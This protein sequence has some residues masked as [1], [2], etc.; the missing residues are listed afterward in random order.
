MFKKGRSRLSLFLDVPCCVLC[1][2]TQSCLTLCDPMDC[3]P[4]GSSV[5][6]ILQART[7]EWV[8]ISSSGRSSWPRDWLPTECCMACAG[9]W[10]L[11]QHCL[12]SPGTNGSALCRERSLSQ[13]STRAVPTQQIWIIRC[14]KPKM[15]WSSQERVLS[16]IGREIMQDL[17]VEALLPAQNGSEGIWAS[18][19]P[20]ALISYCGIS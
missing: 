6:G 7:L 14:E 17:K 2:F 13:W 10:V 5:H 20:P 9:R 8:T 18:L 15:P 3:S 16:G 4:P 11:H 12:G 19:L 1:L